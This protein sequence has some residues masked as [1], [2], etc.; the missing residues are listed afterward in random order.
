MHGPTKVTRLAVRLP[1]E[2]VVALQRI[3]ASLAH[4]ACP[5]SPHAISVGYVLVV[6][7]IPNASSMHL[8]A[9]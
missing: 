1:A 4:R 5:S 8:E 7:N 3:A 6:R 9:V 2:H